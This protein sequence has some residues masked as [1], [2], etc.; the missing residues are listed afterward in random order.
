M[1]RFRFT[2][3][4]IAVHLGAWVPFVLLI[5]D[6]YTDN[7]TVNPIQ[8]ATFRTGKTSLVLLA[9][10]LACTPLSSVAGFRDALKVRR[11]L[12]LYAFFYVCL[13]LTIFAVVDFG[14][15]PQ[16]L[17]EAILEK[18]YALVGFTA[19]LLLVP[20]AITSTRGWM[21]RLGQR[22][23]KLHQLVYVAAGLVI[24]HFVWLV[25]SDVREPLMFGAGLVLLLALRLPAVRRAAANLRFRLA[26]RS[27]R[28]PDPSPTGR[29]ATDTS[30]S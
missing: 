8:A 13:H 1:S 6:F 15:D 11:P 16:L 17:Y 26:R 29:G 25:K 14:L 19:F 9:A 21:K 30:A 24:I 12:G 20:L 22:W 28:S 27:A 7:L 3:F 4:Q 5:W 2:P 18:R 23:K 10:S